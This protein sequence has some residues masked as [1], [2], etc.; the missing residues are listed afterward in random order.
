MSR[1]SEVK[2][3]L[4]ANA[5]LMA[6]LTG[7]IYTS[8][9][10]GVEGVRR[11]VDAP[12][13]AAFDENG[14]LKPCAVVVER[15]L[16]PFGQWRDLKEKITPTSQ[17][18]GIFFYQFRGHSEVA[19]AKNITYTILEGIRLPASYELSWSFETAPL[20]DMGP[21]KNSTVLRQDWQVVS[22]RRPVF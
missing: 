20:Y 1:E 19:L 12:T 15:G 16:V 13:N 21:V 5:T 6:L 10:V 8:E 11:G 4:T 18:V 9:E 3:V 14:N 17:M 2:D 7:G 22:L